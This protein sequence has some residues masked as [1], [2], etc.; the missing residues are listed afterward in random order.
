[1]LLGTPAASLGGSGK[2]QRRQASAS[3]NRQWIGRSPG[4]EELDELPAGAILVPFAAATNDIEKVVEPLLALTVADLGQRQVEAG[5][6][7]ARI[8]RYLGGEL[9]AKVAHD[10]GDHQA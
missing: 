7:V 1:M 8:V 2:E 5:L 9:A 6:M 4:L 10:A 3:G